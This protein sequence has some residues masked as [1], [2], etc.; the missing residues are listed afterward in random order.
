MKHFCWNARGLGSP[1]AVR[2]LRYILKQHHPHLVFLMETKLDS[3]CMDRVRRSCGFTNGINVEAE[4]SRGGLCLAWRDDIGV[5]LRSYSKWH[6]D[7]LIKEEGIQEEWRFTGFY[8]SPYVRDQK[9]VWNLLE[10]LSQDKDYPWLVA[11]DFN[12]IMFSFEKQGGQLRDPRRMETFRDTLANCGLMDVGFSGTWFTW[13]RGNLS[14]TNIRERLDRGVANEKWL[15]LFPM[16]RIQHLPF[17]ISDHCPLLLTT[18]S[19]NTIIRNR[20]FHFETW[21]TMEESFE[22]VL[23]NIW[24]SSSE[25]LIQ[26]LKT[27]QVGL[28]QWAKTLKRKKG[29]LKKKLTEDLESLLGKDRDDE[30]LAKLIDTKIRLNLEID[31]E[32]RYWEQRSRVN[33]LQFGDRNTAFFHKS[34]TTRKKVNLITKLVLD[35]GLEITDETGLQEAAKSYF[36]NLFTSEGV[37]D[38]KKVLEGIESCISQEVNDVLISPFKED[39]VY[40]ALKGMRPLKA[41]GSDGFPA[42]FFQK[43]W[44]IVGK[45]VLEYCL[46]ILNDG[47]EIE[48][49]NM[50]DIVLIPKVSQPTAL[51]NFRPISLCTVVYKLVTKTIANRLQSVIGGCIDKAQS[52]FIPG[53]LISDNV[54][55]AYELLH[56]YRQKRMGKKGYMA[57]K[58]DMSKAYDRVEWDFVI[59]VMRKMGF[60]AIWIRLIMKCITT[61][62][63]TV[64]LNGNR[65]SPFQSSRGLRQGDPLSP[66]L[67]LFCSEGLSALMKMA[68]Q[69][70]LVKG[71]KASRYGPEISHLLFADDCILFG[72]ASERGARVLKEILQEYAD[73]SGQRVN[74]NKSTVFFSANT[75]EAS[76]VLVSSLLEVRTSDNPEKY[77]GLPNMIGR[78]KREAFQ[79]L[80]DR[81]VARIEG[82]SSRLLSQG[83]K[84]IFIK[85]VLQAVPTY[86]MSCFLFPKALCE[87]IESKLAHFWWQKGAGKRGIH[88]CK[89]KYLCR[90]KEE[91]GLAF[92][93]MAQFNLCLLAKQGWRLLLF[94]DS[95]VAQVFKAKYYSNSDFLNSRLGNSCSYV[96]RS[97]WATKDIL[98]RG[99]IWRVGTGQ[100]IS[101]SEDAWIPNY[102]NGRLLSRFVNLQC[103][104]VAELINSSKREWDKGLILNTFSVDVADL[105]LRI[106]L[107]QY[108]HVDRV[109][110]RG[111]PSG[112]FSVRSSY[113][114][115]QSVDPTAYAIQ[116]NYSDFY[117]KLWRIDLPT[118]I[119]IF[120]WKS[121]WNYLATKAN[122]LVRRLAANSLCPRCG[123]AEENMNHLFRRCPVSEEIWR[124][125]LVLDISFFTQEEFGDWLTTV[126]LSMPSEQCR[127]FCVT[128]WAIWGDRNSR[129]HDKIRRSGQETAYFVV[130]YIKELAGVKKSTQHTTALDIRWR[131]PSGQGVKI[132]FDAA[133]DAKNRCSASG[134]VARDSAGQVLV[135][136]TDIHQGVESAFAAEAIACRRATQ[137][138]LGMGGKQINIEGD[139]LSIIKKCNQTDFDKSQIGAFIYDIQRMKNRGSS[140]KFTYSPRSSNKLA[141][142]LA[143]ETLRRNEVFY[144]FH[145][146][147]R[148]AETQRRNDSL[149]EPD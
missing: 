127:I 80:L 25:P 72:E 21:W 32:E 102:S 73:C 5:T 10:R 123:L 124:N 60:S 108:P 110:W 52:A 70:G 93:N 40:A 96:W 109:A 107:S 117:R 33:W 106:P 111:E 81:I 79:N 94:P 49:A 29:V 57:V 74:F 101:I 141:H 50:T 137:I 3:K 45:E 11:G 59:Q 86:A 116:S 38:P 47:K 56:T 98:Q 133:F 126:L 4:G 105:I 132:N 91:G 104:N 97:I 99:L 146:V 66:F 85:S 28:E 90:P 26:K 147:P 30:T 125:L 100:D 139:S 92:R 31:K 136:A 121:S 9:Y 14:E 54:I 113:K 120:I 44:H 23:R 20:R 138:A 48:A 112:E 69:N 34:A 61:V 17:I 95:L 142:L 83:G 75:S 76:K 12:E 129:I 130:S 1:R 65:G 63:Y 8:G 128:M 89:W 16:G 35:E 103:G 15:T 7:V 6:I 37:A 68:K 131:H 84:E 140:L 2:R 18:D 41:P 114:L 148:F 122:M 13:E 135:S 22:G 144:L 149:R 36:E 82:W 115:L 77:L 51:V 39:E 19:D 55:L 145:C 62:S 42:L 119:K 24:E 143:T 64:I 134:V 88:W 27:L 71:A 78:R 53:L 58:L 118:K 67:F 46:G 87:R 43:Y